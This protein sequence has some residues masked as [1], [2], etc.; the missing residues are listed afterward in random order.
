MVL[1][2]KYNRNMLIIEID[3]NENKRTIRIYISGCKYECLVLQDVL[4]H[5]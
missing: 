1:R 5:A 4:H 2:N 3:L